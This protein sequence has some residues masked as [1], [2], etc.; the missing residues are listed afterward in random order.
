MIDVLALAS[1]IAFV[2]GVLGGL[3]VYEV[4]HR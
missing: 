2:F 1:A 3:F 4:S